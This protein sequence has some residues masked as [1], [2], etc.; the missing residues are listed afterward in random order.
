MQRWSEPTL[1]QEDQELLPLSPAAFFILF[2]LADGEKHGYKIMQDVKALSDAK[3]KL[4]PATLYTTI[5]KL[6]GLALIEEA[7]HTGEDRRRVYRL[8]PSG[9]RLLGAEFSRQRDV[10]L[11]ARKKK[12]FPLG[13]KA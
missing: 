6:S 11:L 5:Q 10:L 3:L 2:A 9:K 12:I 4:G 8:T 7:T 1:S 13:G